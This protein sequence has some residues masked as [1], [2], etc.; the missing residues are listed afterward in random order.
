MILR[1]DAFR[2]GQ[3]CHPAEMSQSSL[4]R[5]ATIR[6][7]TEEKPELVFRQEPVL[8]KRD[9]KIKVWE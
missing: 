4:L 1:F 8:Q 5:A 3:P 7:A 9:R 2:L 6:L